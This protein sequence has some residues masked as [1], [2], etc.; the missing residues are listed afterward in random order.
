MGKMA[1]LSFGQG[2]NDQAKSHFDEA[3]ALLRL[4]EIIN[5][6]SLELALR[7]IDLDKAMDL[8]TEAGTLQPNQLRFINTHAF[9]RFQLGEYDQAKALMEEGINRL[10]GQVDGPTLEQYGDILMKLN[11]VDQAVEQWQKAKKLGKTSGKLD[12][13][14]ANKEYF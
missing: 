4:P 12:Q 9:V 1:E 8:A 14:I 3:L 13:K 7:Q 10:S 2:E 11:L 6:Y 5:N